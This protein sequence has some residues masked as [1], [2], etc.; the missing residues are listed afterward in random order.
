MSASSSIPL[1]SIQD[2]SW[3]SVEFFRG[4]IDLVLGIVQSLWEIPQEF[5]ERIL[6][7]EMQ[8]MKIYQGL[9]IKY[10]R[11]SYFL[12]LK[13]SDSPE[14]VETRCEIPGSTFTVVRPVVLGCAAAMK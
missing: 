11:F 8:D 6:P 7:K 5:M 12:Y 4:H 9:F 14:S 10:I 1:C 13:D 2:P 3:F